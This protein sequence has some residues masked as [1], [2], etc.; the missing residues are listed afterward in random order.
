MKKDT[1]EKPK[2]DFIKKY[3]D[4]NEYEFMFQAILP[5]S[6]TNG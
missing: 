6:G 4:A 5:R 3:P 2:L 1:K